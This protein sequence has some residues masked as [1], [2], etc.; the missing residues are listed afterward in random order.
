MQ[1][2]TERK[3]WEEEIR[4]HLEELQIEIDQS[5]RATEVEMITRSN[6]FQEIQEEISGFDLDQ[7]W[8]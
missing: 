6:Y 3:R 8:S 7:F 4:R 1:D 5:R 2:I